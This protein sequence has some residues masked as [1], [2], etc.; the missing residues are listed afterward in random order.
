[1]CRNDKMSLVRYKEP[2][3]YINATFCKF[4]DF[5]LEDLGV[6][7]YAV[8]DDVDTFF[9]KDTGRNGVKYEFLSVELDGMTG[10]RS[11]LKTSYDVIMR[12]EGI[13]DLTFTF[14]AP[15]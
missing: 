11:A 4:V 7:D 14:V 1:M 9:V 12:C 3:F 6:D 15:L 8:A 10:I 5:I 2:V 13:D